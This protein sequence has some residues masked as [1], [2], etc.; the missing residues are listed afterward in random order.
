VLR[1]AA[2]GL[3]PT[4][5]VGPRRRHRAGRI[6]GV[7]S[8]SRQIRS[9]CHR[10]RPSCA[11]RSV[12]PQGCRTARISGHSSSGL[13]VA[14]SGRP[15]FVGRQIWATR[16]RIRLACPPPA[17]GCLCPSSPCLPAPSR[18]LCRPPIAPW[19]TGLRVRRLHWDDP[20]LTPS[21]LLLPWMCHLLLFQP[22]PPRMSAPSPL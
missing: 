9:L 6:G 15:H 7:P 22:L 2:L 20:Y 14:A 11:S 16:H 5:I 3:G 1:R 19:R 10:V 13:M 21:W 17:K 12:R 4:L 8:G 18:R